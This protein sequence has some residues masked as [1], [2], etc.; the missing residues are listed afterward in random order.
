MIREARKAGAS[1]H[2]VNGW[3]YGYA[4]ACRMDRL[5]V[6]L[7]RKDYL[8]AFD[9]IGVQNEQIRSLLSQSGANPE[10]IFVTGNMKFDSIQNGEAG[11]ADQTASDIISYLTQTQSPIIVAGCLGDIDEC[12][13]LF[14]AIDSI[15]TTH[16][17]THYI[18]A[19]RHPENREFMQLLTEKLDRKGL[20]YQMKSRMEPGKLNSN[21]FLILDTFGELKS[22]YAIAN[23]CYVGCNHNVLEPLAFGKTTLVSGN[24][25]TQYPSYPVY[26]LTR[27]K[28]LIHHA[29]GAGEIGDTIVKYISKGSPDEHESDKIINQLYSLSGAVDRTLEMIGLDH[30]L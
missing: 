10:R 11:H 6:N 25:N 1:I 16:P 14:D 24:W 12:Y 18:I 13:A 8:D 3:L 22:F 20:T 5:E 30:R 9:T 17:D 2:L 19:P 7:F 4:P 29:E 23:I 26:Q 21:I 15:R 28:G 27:E